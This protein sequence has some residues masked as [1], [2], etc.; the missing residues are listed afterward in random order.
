MADR[1][2]GKVA[3]VTGAANG[4]GQGC[5]RVFA[6]EGAVVIGVDREDCDLT[7]EPQVQAFFEQV[8]KAHGRIDV[9]VN[10]AAFA[11][12]DWIESLSYADWK[13]TLTGELDIVFLG[14]RGL[15]L[16]QGQRKGERHQLCFGQCAPRARRQPGAGALRGQGRG[17]R[18]D[19]PAGYGGGTPQHPR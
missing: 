18:H 5:A 6:S 9:L 13:A 3:L 1:L 19:A 12:F 8:G 10:A 11:V 2:K 14:A 16:A 4:I 7:D 17:A 15:A